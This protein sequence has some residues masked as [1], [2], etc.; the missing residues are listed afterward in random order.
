MIKL[1]KMV[2]NNASE[3]KF[4]GVAGEIITT[5]SPLPFKSRRSWGIDGI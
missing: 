5:Y 2:F 3:L 4:V 1:Y